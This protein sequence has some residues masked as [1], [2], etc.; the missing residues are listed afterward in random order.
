MQKFSAYNQTPKITFR[1]TDKDN[2]TQLF[3]F[4]CDTIVNQFE[5]YFENKL[6][7]QIQYERV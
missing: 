3:T 4:G 1:Y 5:K 7:K 6:E 2:H